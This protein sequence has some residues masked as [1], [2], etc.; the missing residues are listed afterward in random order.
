MNVF[1][2]TVDEFVELLEKRIADRRAA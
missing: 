2:L 1:K